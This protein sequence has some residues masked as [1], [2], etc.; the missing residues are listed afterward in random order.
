MHTAN[1]KASRVLLLRLP[2]PSSVYVVSACSPT[3][4]WSILTLLSRGRCCFDR[5]Q[6]SCL[7]QRREHRIRAH[8]WAALSRAPSLIQ[9]RTMGTASKVISVIFRLAEAVASIILLGL[10]GTFLGIVS[11]AGVYADPRVIY[12]I[13]IAC[14]GVFLSLLFMLPFT[15]S[16]MVF[17]MD[18]VMFLLFLVAFCLLEAV[19]TSP[20]AGTTPHLDPS[21]NRAQA[22]RHKSLH[23]SLVLELLGL[24]LG[25]VLDD[26][27]GCGQRPLGHWLGWLW[28]LESRPRLD[29]HSINPLFVQLIPGEPASPRTVASLLP[30]DQ[31]YM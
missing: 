28:G 8:T 1:Q 4:C 16:F 31:M 2:R 30:S 23:F 11:N 29:L 15:Y 18:F 9:S 5:T 26:S 10:L 17:P 25:W 13:V 14:M 12:A 22:H 3:P 20:A 24:L 7:P 27:R 6:I 21:D 19:S